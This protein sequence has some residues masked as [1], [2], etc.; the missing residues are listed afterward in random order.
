MCTT[1]TTTHLW[2]YVLYKGV[3]AYKQ[4]PWPFMALKALREEILVEPFSLICSQPEHQQS[5][6]RHQ[7]RGQYQLHDA[8][9]LRDQ[10][11]RRWVENNEI[12]HSKNPEKSCDF[13]PCVS[14]GRFVRCWGLACSLVAELWEHHKQVSLA[15]WRQALSVPGHKQNN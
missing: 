4:F 3:K 14:A 12:K 11:T 6:H 9:T 13:T 5:H 2:L 7:G 10:N 15:G 1:T 8:G